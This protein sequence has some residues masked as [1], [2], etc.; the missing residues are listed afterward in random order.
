VAVLWSSSSRLW[1]FITEPRACAFGNCFWSALFIYRIIPALFFFLG[2]PWIF[3]LFA[4]H[5]AAPLIPGCH[6]RICRHSSALIACAVF[7]G[8]ATESF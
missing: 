2:F 3:P 5:V 6:T 8:P 1:L 4:S 7:L